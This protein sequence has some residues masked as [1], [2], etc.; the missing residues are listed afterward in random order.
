MELHYSDKVELKRRI[1]K[2][3]EEHI[4]L[5]KPGE[6]TMVYIQ[7]YGQHIPLDKYKKE[8]MCHKYWSDSM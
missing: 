7:R 5:P 1:A 4:L 6:T 8:G 2:K 3:Y